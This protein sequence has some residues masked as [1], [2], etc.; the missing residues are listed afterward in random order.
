MYTP[1]GY[2][3]GARRYPVIYEAPWGSS[4]FE[5]AVHI[6]EALDG[7]ITAGTIPAT[8]MVFVAEN[9]GPYADSECI[10]SADGREWFERYLTQTVLPYV[11]ANFQTMAE[12]RARTLFGFSHGGYCASML[13]LRHPDLFRN[14]ISFSGYFQ[15]AIRSEQTP[16][17]WR[18]YG[19]NKA[20][21]SATSPIEEAA[22]V[23]A[24]LRSSLFI[25][26]SASPTE[27]F[28]GPP[29]LSF[30]AAI[31]NNGINLSVF[32]TPLGHAWRAIASQ[33]SSVLQTL[34]NREIATGTF[35][36]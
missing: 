35:S 3:D 11:D 33:L 10:D 19:D 1:P 16:T 12:P 28:C 32:P 26:L 24:G 2:P 7:L 21:I 18:P 36:G 6:T 9:G 34:A 20:L 14:A 29:Y 27:P 17:A 4:G 13:L 30:A 22:T 8:L 5:S 15:A 23:P 25:E 31:R